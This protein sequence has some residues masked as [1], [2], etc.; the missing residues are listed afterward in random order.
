MKQS[1]ARATRTRKPSLRRGLAMFLSDPAKYIAALKDWKKLT[2]DGADPIE[3]LHGHKCDP[4]C[5][6][7]QK[8]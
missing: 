1:R 6:H 3:A 2:D 7:K 8:I 5:M 4:G